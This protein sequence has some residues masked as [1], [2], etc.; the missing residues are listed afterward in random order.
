MVERSRPRRGRLRRILRIAGLAVVVVLALAVGGLIVL[1]GTERGQDNLGAFI[2]RL[3]STPEQKIEVGGLSGILSGHLRLDHVVVGDRDGDWL[4]I[5]N[6]ALDWSPLALFSGTFH[7]ERLAAGR[8]EVAR[9]PKSEESAQKSGGSFSLPVSVDVDRIELPDIALGPELAG[10]IASLS[11]SGTVHAAAS[12]L[13]VDAEL[14]A[15]RTDGKEG[16]LQARVRY[17]PD[18]ND[19]LDLDVTANE[20]QGGILATLL[21]LPGAPDVGI[22]I[23]GGGALA[24]WSGHARFTVDGATVTRLDARHR[25]TETGRVVEAKGSGDFS[26]FA[27]ATFAPLISGATNF[28]LAGTLTREGGVVIDRA[29]LDTG[30]VRAT[31][32]GQLDPAGVSDFSVELASEGAPVPLA[33]GSEES[34]IT[35]AIRSASIRA[36]GDGATPGLDI[37]AELASVETRD[38]RVENAAL[39]LHSDA[40]AIAARTGPVSGTASATKIAMDNAVVTPLI[41]GQIKAGF[42]GEL[43]TDALTVSS[44]TF[45]SDAVEG[46]FNGRVSMADGSISIN[47]DTSVASSALPA[48]V[49]PA[50]GERAALKGTIARDAEG[51]I[52][53]RGIQLSSGGFSAGGEA[54]LVDGVLNAVLKGALAD[55]SALAPQASGDLVFDVSA[56]GALATP[57][58]VLSLSSAR[59]IVADREIEGL[60]LD[61]SGKADMEN[62]AANVSLSGKVAGEALAGKAVLSSANGASEVR[63]L[64]LTL[65]PNSISGDLVLDEAFVP[66]GK[67]VLNIPQL[68]PLAALALQTVEGDLSGTVDFT[69]ENG[70]PK[71]A[72]DVTSQSIRQGEVLVAGASVKAAVTDYMAAPGAA[73]TIRAKTVTSGSTVVSDAAVD[74]AQDGPWTG[75]DGGATVSG[76]PAKAK[77]R[78]KLVDGA[79]TIELASADATMRGVRAALAK[80]T[81][82]AIA[83]GTTRLNDLT[84]DVGGG[85]VSVTGTAGSALALKVGIASM[86]A[87]IA[88]AFAPG[89]GLAGTISGSADVSGAASAPKVGY[90]LN[91]AGAELQQ[92]KSAGLAPLAIGSTGTFSGNSLDFRTTIGGPGGLALQGGGRVETAG[93]GALSV[94]ISGGVPLSLA[95]AQL[96]SAGA[97]LTGTANV[98]VSVRG[99]TSAPVIGGSVKAS[100]ARLVSATTGIALNDL[101]ADISMADNVV[102]INRLTGKI[103]TGGT[104]SASGTVGIDGT[105]PADIAVK[106]VD[107]RYTDGRIVATTLNGD[108]TLK[109]PLLSGPTAAGTINLGRT[110]ITVPDRLPASL[111]QLDVK[112]QNAPAAVV[113]QQEALAP[114]SPSGQGSGLVNLDLTINAPQQIF[115]QGRGIDAEL[116]GNLKLTGSTAA[117]SA[118]GEFKL[119]R[120]RLSILARRLDFTSGTIGFYGSLI[121]TLNFV[122]ESKTSTATVT[123][124][125]T[126]QADNPKFTF[127]SVPALPQDEALAQLIF[128]RSMSNLSPLQIAQLAQAAA[129]L[130]GV[131]GST[132]LLE[133]IQRQIGV[134]DLDLK[135]TDDGGTA[136]SAGKYLNDRTYITIEKGDRPGS[137]KAGIDL[138]V[139]RGIKLRGEARDDGEAKGGIFFER[140]Y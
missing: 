32:G 39:A 110:V 57:D 113:R 71:L 16:S 139:G 129:Q 130:A 114:S 133:N 89:L 102:R 98:S 106:I 3:A 87:A 115:V 81:T 140:E 132:S 73:G 58:V 12:P 128:G 104:I 20:P 116:G 42:A 14:T 121:P 50:L 46:K 100:G 97:S 85:R 117:P 127:S 49:R 131:G 88:N 53:A 74:L 8:I 59:I 55:I 35:L 105:M 66:E 5:K 111:S 76:I 56:K 107:G 37:A 134:D 123:V 43:S 119:R 80:P 75:F 28:D 77:G 101:S 68:G 122:A 93:S 27:P 41:S 79:T 112:H 109:G 44:G 24:D 52:S 4:A 135:T 7:A 118:L 61:A 125:V 136:V 63:E 120:G 29:V 90:S 94:D 86:P 6:V 83:D 36:L 65:G 84:L 69:R 126:G 47:L 38:V 11:A 124:N 96:A 40:F 108:V 23:K 82:V 21:R 17:L 9:L 95:A 103:S 30:V 92:T 45:N 18:E 60:K 67:V 64:S 33:L 34:P 48:P 62:P 138:D 99:T 70:K 22:S 10:G 13:A 19:T 31:A 1:T 78:V 51:S 72:V 2:S 26:R 25:L 91:W 54:T 15:A 137:G